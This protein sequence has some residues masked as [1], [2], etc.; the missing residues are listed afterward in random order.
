LQERLEFYQESKEFNI[1]KIIKVKVSKEE[2]DKMFFDTRV[3]EG[4]L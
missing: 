4:E 2:F 3:L 1:L